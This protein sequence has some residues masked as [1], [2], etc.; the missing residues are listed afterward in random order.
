MEWS[1]L[2]SLRDEFISD[3]SQQCRSIVFLFSSVEGEN[4]VSAIKIIDHT[5]L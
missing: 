4:K 3:I 1:L 5:T 2:A